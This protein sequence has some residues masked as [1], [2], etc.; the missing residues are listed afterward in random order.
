ME[1]KFFCKN[2]KNWKQI[3]QNRE[4]CWKIDEIENSR[5]KS[6][7]IFYI[8]ILCRVRTKTILNVLID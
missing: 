6:R 4:K 8:I 3:Y 1:N 2:S 7:L 5:E